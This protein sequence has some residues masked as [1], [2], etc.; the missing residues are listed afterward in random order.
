HWPAQNGTA[1]GCSSPEN[2]KNK[3]AIVADFPGGGKFSGARCGKNLQQR[4]D[5]GSRSGGE[6]DGAAS[7]YGQGTSCHDFLL[8]LRS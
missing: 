3:G 4:V 8:M 2:G 5:S 1:W 6:S 7:L